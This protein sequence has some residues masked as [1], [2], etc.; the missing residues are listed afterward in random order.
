MRHYPYEYLN[1]TDFL[2]ELYGSPVP[3]QYFKITILDWQERPLKEIQGLVTGGNLN[4]DGKSALRRTCNLSA[5]ID[6]ETANI[7]EVNNLFSLN[8]KMYLE[9]GL[10]NTTYDKYKQYETIWFPQGL[11]IMCGV[12]ISHNTQ[13]S[14]ISLTL[15]DKMCL[16]NGD[17]AGC[18]P[19]TIEFDKYDTH[20]ADGQWITLRP[21]IVQIIRELV[22]HW[23]GEQ[24]GKIYINDLDTRVK[25]VMK[26]TGSKPVYLSNYDKDVSSGNVQLSMNRSIFKPEDTVR[27]YFYGDDIGY[28]LTDF[29]YPGELISNAGETICSIL[30][31]IKNTLGN[32]EYFYDIDGNFIF[33]E[34]KNY[35]NTTKATHVEKYFLDELYNDSSNYLLKISEGKRAFTFTNNNLITSFTNTPQYNR[36][37]NDFIVWGIRKNANGNDVPIRYRLVID[38]RPE[39]GNTYPCFKY[40][41]SEDGLTKLKKPVEY[42]SKS[43]FPQTGSVTTFYLDKSSGI[44]YKW[45][46]SEKGYVALSG[47][48]IETYSSFSEFPNP[49]EQ[50]KIY[51]AQ[52]ENEQY[53]WG[54]N[55]E[56]QHYK[57]IEQQ[58]AQ[59]I[60]EMNK[61]IKDKEDE[62]DALKKEAEPVADRQYELQQQAL[63]LEVQIDAQEIEILEREKEIEDYKQAIEEHQNSI[64]EIQKIMLDTIE[65]IT[66]DRNWKDTLGQYGRGNIDLWNR[67]Q[68]DNGD[69]TISTVRSLG[70]YDEDENSIFYGK[71]ILAPTVI[72]NAIVSD[73]EAIAHYYSSGEYFG[74]FNTIDESNAY[75]E[76]LH[77]Q[78]AVLY[79]QIEASGQIYLIKDIMHGDILSQK[80]KL[81]AGIQS[82]LD[83]KILELSK[84]K[85]AL[86]ALNTQ[87]AVLEPQLEEINNQAKELSNRINKVKEDIKTL[88]EE[89]ED[90]LVQLEK[91]QYEYI[92]IDPVN[93]TNYT[94]TDWRTELYL[95]GVQADPLGTDSNVYYAELDAEWPK[96]FDF[97]T[98]T[99]HNEVTQDYTSIDY[100]LDFLDTNAAVGAFSVNNI[101]RRTHVITDNSVNCIFEPYIPDVVLIESGQKDTGDKRDEAIDRNLRFC[102]VDSTLYS[103]LTTGG[104]H[105]SAYEVV[106][107]LLYQYT[108]YNENIT[109]QSLP[110]FHL[111]PNIRI[112]V[113]D[114]ESNIYGDYMISTISIPLNVAGTMSINATRALEK[115]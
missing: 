6:I 37:K 40:E 52:K 45:A 65:E 112:G 96:L 50:D 42:Q 101:G 43:N 11:F 70:F 8:K 82:A 72:G 99:Y 25:Q 115:I 27:E 13:G 98:N 23:G 77:I 12:N 56:S 94:T 103:Q 33:Q 18:L 5:Y 22:N 89:K 14:N 90:G 93:F 60:E 51:Y 20:T 2:D 100:Y 78:Q 44:I 26:W 75:A 46:G 53:I 59:F 86:T 57:K 74:V 81:V 105:N 19:S 41:D 91:E 55:K 7:T 106:K 97:N 80:N 4:L 84:E 79:S 111:E 16:L 35:L 15:K 48:T 54:L 110:M 62:L 64:E 109:I 28:I 113:N 21:T 47:E 24:L 38:K 10:K 114:I 108:S 36:I 66:G 49:G 92:K 29:T 67:P 104:T 73:D 87:L 83:E 69:G 17:V 102:Q 76:E 30:D 68:V 1:D 61:K 3:E 88:K 9:I 95:K 85:A 32:Y 34:I 39:I 71:E 31:K 58:E 63:T 107:D